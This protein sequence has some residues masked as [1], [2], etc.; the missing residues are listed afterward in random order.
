MLSIILTF[1]HAFYL[2][3]LNKILIMALLRLFQ[4]HFFLLFKYGF[5]KKSVTERCM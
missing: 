1:I 2:R 4:V 3:I 5:E